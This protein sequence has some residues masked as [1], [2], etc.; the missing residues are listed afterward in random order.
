M[1]ITEGMF[2][3]LAGAIDRPDLVEDP[4]FAD[5][6]ARA[7]HG[8][9]LYAIVAE[10]T[11]QRDKHEA[12]RILGEAGVPASAVLDTQD[13]FKDPHL[14]ARGFVHQVDHGALGDK[15]LLGWPARMSASEVPICRAPEL[16]EHTDEVLKAELGVDDEGLARLRQ[17]GVIA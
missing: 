13:L 10:W 4:R 6:R 16:G 15:P 11:S 7:R 5:P 14:L 17:A 3:D 9:E 2:R 8:D 1:A 12:M